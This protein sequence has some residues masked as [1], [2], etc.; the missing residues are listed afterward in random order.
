MNVGDNQVIT[1]ARVTKKTTAAPKAAPKAAKTQTTSQSS[2]SVTVSQ[3]QE[4]YYDKRYKSYRFDMEGFSVAVMVEMLREWCTANNYRY[5]ITFDIVQAS[6][7][8][9]IVKS[10]VTVR[11][12]GDGVVITTQGLSGQFGVSFIDMSTKT[13]VERAQTVALGKALALGGFQLPGNSGSAEEYLLFTAL[14]DFDARQAHNEVMTLASQLPE[15]IKKQLRRNGL[16]S[17]EQL[18][19]FHVKDITL[20]DFQAAIQTFLKSRQVSEG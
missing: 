18:M 8:G 16:T 7:T 15:D 6:A 14:K 10:D 1:M 12:Q 3:L 9:V 17:V 2:S 4:K 19:P 11:D 5:C 20:E 13:L